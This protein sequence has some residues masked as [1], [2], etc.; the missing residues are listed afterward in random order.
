MKQ[1]TRSNYRLHGIYI[2]LYH[3][4]YHTLYHSISAH[5]NQLSL[6]RT[7]HYRNNQS[8]LMSLWKQNTIVLIITNCL[9]DIC[10]HL[11]RYQN[12]SDT[13]KCRRCRQ[14]NKTKYYNKIITILKIQLLSKQLPLLSLSFLLVLCE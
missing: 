13:K 10:I 4:A 7:Y 5:Q 6:V 14:Q 8:A 9:S 1:C 11:S 12:N 2:K 3:I